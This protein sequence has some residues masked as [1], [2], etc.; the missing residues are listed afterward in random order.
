MTGN[1]KKLAKNKQ[2]GIF[3]YINLKIIRGD[4]TNCMSTVILVRACAE[5]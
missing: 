5:H 3:S 1:Y 2:V 4:W